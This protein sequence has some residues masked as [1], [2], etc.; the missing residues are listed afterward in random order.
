M[1]ESSTISHKTHDEVKK[2]QQQDK[3][4]V[5]LISYLDERK[6]PEDK[7]EA[8]KILKMEGQLVLDTIG[9][10]FRHT[11][12]GK[13][14]LNQLVVPK[15]LINELSEWCHDY[16][17]S[18]HFGI[19]KTY[20]RTRSSSYYW[21]NMFANIKRWVR[22]CISCSQKKQDHHH[23]HHHHRHKAPFLPIPISGPSETV[24]ADLWDNYVLLHLTTD[25]SQ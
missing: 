11:N 15:I 19:N 22:S 4:L 13:R 17:N 2:M 5:N 20:E 12:I 23:H 18:G 6:L 25:V 8:S 1:S 9:L 10:L 7:N 16:I 21:Y 14:S 3:N 24:T